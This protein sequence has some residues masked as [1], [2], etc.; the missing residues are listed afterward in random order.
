MKY[1][2][3]NNIH[4]L[5]KHTA[6]CRQCKKRGLGFFRTR[7]TGKNEKRRLNLA[8]CRYCEQ[9][10]PLKM[11]AEVGEQS[12]ESIERIDAALDAVDK[13]MY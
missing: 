7:D 4:S 13:T 12:L 3:I 8:W 6:E 5:F 9:T 1:K 2:S 11:S 10:F